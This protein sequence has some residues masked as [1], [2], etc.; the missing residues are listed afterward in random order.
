ML[1]NEAAV[2]QGAVL[3][4][5]RSR[6]AWQEGAEPEDSVRCPRH[7]IPRQVMLEAIELPTQWREF[8]DSQQAAWLLAHQEQSVI[9]VVQRYLRALFAAKHKDGFGAV[10]ASRMSRAVSSAVGS[11]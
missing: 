2:G 7:D 3:V 1:R 9:A 4:Q 10:Y 11:R 6:V 8:D 5:Q